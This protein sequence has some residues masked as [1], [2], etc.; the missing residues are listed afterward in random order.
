[1][2][3]GPDRL[4]DRRL[5]IDPMLVVKVDHLDSQPLQAG[6]A[7]FPDVRRVA[8]DAEPLTIWPSDVAELR[9]QHD[10]VAAT[11]DRLA[12]EDLV[13]PHAVDVSCVEEVAARV[14]VAV[15][16]ADR[17]PLVQLLGVVEVAHPHAAQ[18]DCRYLEAALAQFALGHHVL[19]S[20]LGRAKCLAKLAC[21]T[22][23]AMPCPHL[24]D[25]RSAGSFRA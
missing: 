1:R 15:D 4:L 13:T 23:S 5:R 22:F 7:A 21:D 10:L 18:A 3:H 6:L 11:F 20:L 19:L 14:E 8:A 16:D 12:N 17:L 24:R 9:R 2:G 25:C